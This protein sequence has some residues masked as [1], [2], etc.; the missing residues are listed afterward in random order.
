[1]YNAPRD[2]AQAV[3]NAQ[4][5]AAALPLRQLAARHILVVLAALDAVQD[6]GV[7]SAQ[8]NGVEDR[9][10]CRVR[11][12]GREELY[13]MVEVVGCPYGAGVERPFVWEN[14]IFEVV[15]AWCVSDSSL[16]NVQ[17]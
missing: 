9:S 10:I 16:V 15:V 13:W 8:P 1:M 6:Q 3:V 5:D 4:D 17:C 2:T 7:G 11:R 14:G 12:D